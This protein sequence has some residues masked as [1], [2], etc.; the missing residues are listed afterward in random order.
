MNR[1]SIA[2]QYL[3]HKIAAPIQAHLGHCVIQICNS[4]DLI[5]TNSMLKSS[6]AAVLLSSLFCHY[7]MSR[8]FISICFCVFES[9][10]Y[11]CL[12][13]NWLFVHMLNV[14]LSQFYITCKQSFFCFTHCLQRPINSY[15]YF[16]R[17]NNVCWYFVWLLY[18]NRIDWF[19]LCVRIHSQIVSFHLKHLQLFTWTTFLTNYHIFWLIPCSYFECCD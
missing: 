11:G 16:H 1:P 19:C 6:V 17:V 8:P 7:S 3:Q 15:R 14:S 9:F 12:F 13:F 18:I 5:S 2:S 10:I 4:N